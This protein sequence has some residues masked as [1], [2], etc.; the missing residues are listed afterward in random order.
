METPV[1]RM[2]RTGKLLPCNNS[3]SGIP[4]CLRLPCTEIVVDTEFRLRHCH[5]AQTQISNLSQSEEKIVLIVGET[6]AGKSTFINSV[7]NSYYGT[8]WDDQFRLVLISPEDE[9]DAGVIRTQ[10]ESQT[11]WV[12][13]YTLYY[14]PDCAVEYTLTLIDTPGY[15]DPRGVERDNQTTARLKRFFTMKSENGGIDQINGI[16]FVVKSST[17]RLTSAQQY[18]FH[19][20]LSVFGRDIKEN[21]MLVVTH[22]GTGRPDAI[23][24]AKAAGIPTEEYFKFDNSVLLHA[25]VKT[26]VDEG[27][28]NDDDSYAVD[29]D[30]LTWKSNV[31]HM[32]KF[33]TKLSKLQPQ[34]LQLTREVLDQRQHLKMILKNHRNEIDAA[35][36]NLI[37]LRQETDYLE[38]HSST[39][40]VDTT[41]AEGMI[42]SRTLQLMPL[43]GQQRATNCDSCK[44]TC[45]FPC[46]LNTEELWRCWAMDYHYYEAALNAL[47]ILSS[48]ATNC[49]MCPNKCPASYHSNAN[50]QYQYIDRIRPLTLENIQQ[51][52]QSPDEEVSPMELGERVLQASNNERVR[53]QKLL[54]KAHSIILRLDEIALQ[55]QRHE[56]SCFLQE[57]IY[58]EEKIG[59]DGWQGRV[60]QLTA[61]VKHD[62]LIEEIK[63]HS[64]NLM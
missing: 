37:S 44:R 7:V 19:S 2:F 22:A 23:E 28:L 51:Q 13:V 1:R 4:S 9:T 39:P 17:N 35:L 54:V 31:Y 32:N 42:R 21:M 48:R 6:G 5:V 57:M 61:I 50:F 62:K 12:T 8:Q 36:I 56:V 59:R 26:G 41:L 27:D 46:T 11:D 20:V 3:R 15:N 60:E 49:T 10:T 18:V 43:S 58:E 38:R 55:P 45:H 64:A 63:L 52:H 25:N 53:I 24:A 14:Q 40:G 33:Y 30:N 47:N 16:F 29:A 34:S